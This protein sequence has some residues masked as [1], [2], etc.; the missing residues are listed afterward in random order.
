ME[1]QVNYIVQVIEIMMSRN[2][3]AIRPGKEA[4]K[5]YMEEIEGAL[6]KTVWSTGDCNAWYSDNRGN[7]TALWPYNSSSYWMRTRNV[8]LADYE[9]N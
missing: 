3:K 4:E 2:I 5:M 9:L 7:I 1:C 6:K 8:N